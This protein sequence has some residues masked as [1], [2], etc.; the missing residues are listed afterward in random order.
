MIESHPNRAWPPP[1]RPWLL[2]MT[3]QDLL[4][5]HW[6]VPETSLRPHIPRRLELET[7]N[8]A[9]WLGIVPFGMVG[10]RPRWLPAIPGVSNFPELNVRTYITAEGKPGVWFFSLDAASRLAVRGARAFFHLMYYDAQMS[11]QCRDDGWIHYRS[12]RT[13]RGAPPAEFEAIYRPTGQPHVAPPGS[14]DSWLTDRYCLYSADRRG[15][16]YRAEIHHPPWPLQPAEMQCE[17]NTMTQQLDLALPE[18]SPVL[19][20]AKEMKVV[21]WLLERLR[22]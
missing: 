5:A 19:H 20:F 8:G 4:F 11:Q 10:T 7:W 2:A 22:D 12:R 21:G 6:P 15:N 9:A 17:L 3:W 18:I 13:H 14:F 1:E 16:V